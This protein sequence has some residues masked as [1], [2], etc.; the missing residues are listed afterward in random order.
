[1]SR[2]A[3][4]TISLPQ[5]LLSFADQIAREQATSRSKVISACIEEVAERRRIAQLEEGYKAMAEVNRTFAGDAVGIV[6]EA[7]PPWE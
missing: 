2:V 5:H 3:K 4:L 1:M 7:L 6:R